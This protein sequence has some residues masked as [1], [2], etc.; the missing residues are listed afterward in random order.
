MTYGDRYEPT[1]IA[2]DAAPLQPS[3]CNIDMFFF[4]FY[5]I[6]IVVATRVYIIYTRILYDME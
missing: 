6:I 1:R 5:Y 4:F 2:T 3:A